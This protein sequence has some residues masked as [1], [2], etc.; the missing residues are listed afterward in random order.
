MKINPVKKQTHS[1]ILTRLTRAA[2]ED[3][4]ILSI[5]KED[6]LSWEEAKSL[7]EQE[8][9]EHRAQIDTK[10]IP[11]KLFLSF[12]F[13]VTGIIMT[14]GPVFYL[15]NM[16][17]IT[18]AFVILFSGGAI[19]SVDAVIRLMGSRCALL[20]WYELPSIVFTLMLGVGIIVANIQYLH[21]TWL[22]FL[23]NMNT[24]E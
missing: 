14:V 10:Q 19:N 2:S 24:G 5:C 9:L 21:D 22:N 13:L 4:V 3:D 18:R 1:Y 12:L 11:I 8:K 17:D 20:S 7:V 15:W 16:L 6:G 23:W